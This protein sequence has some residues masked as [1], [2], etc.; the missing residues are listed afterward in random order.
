[1]K[2]RVDKGKCIGCGLC[3]ETCPNVFRMDDDG[4]AVAKAEAI[5]KAD[6]ADA[7]TAAEVCPAGAIEIKPAD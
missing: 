7:E 5:D 6:E 1:M 4:L 3:T 2:A